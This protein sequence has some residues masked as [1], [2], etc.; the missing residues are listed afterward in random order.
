MLKTIMNID[1]D[2][3]V[4]SPQE[5]VGN[6][7]NTHHT[8]DESQP[9]GDHTSNNIAVD[10][11]GRGTEMAKNLRKSYADVVKSEKVANVTF[12]RK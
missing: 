12:S 7:E 6:E 11:G 1:D 4:S 5:C 8:T 3:I 2:F 9:A 10:A